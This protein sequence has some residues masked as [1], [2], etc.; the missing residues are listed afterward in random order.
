[1][2]VRYFSDDKMCIVQQMMA[3]PPHV[4]NHLYSLLVKRCIFD[5]AKGLS[6]PDVH[7]STAVLRCQTICVH[8]DVAWSHQYVDSG[9]LSCSGLSVLEFS[10]Q[11]KLACRNVI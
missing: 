7:R 8:E 5:S 10:P 2:R 1:M 3:P 6:A 11:D 4:P 9:S